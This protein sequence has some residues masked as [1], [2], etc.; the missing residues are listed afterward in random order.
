MELI[1]GYVQQRLESLGRDKD[2]IHPNAIERFVKNCRCLHIERMRSVKD[3]Y[4]NPDIDEIHEAFDD[5]DMSMLNDDGGPEQPKLVNWY[6]AFRALDEFVNSEGR[7]P[8]NTDATVDADVEK[9]KACQTELFKK[10][11]LDRDDFNSAC[12][13]E[14][15]RF[16]GCEPHT[17]AAFLGGVVSQAVLKIVLRQ[18]YPF[19]HTLIYDGIFCKCKTFKF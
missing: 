10:I 13:D 1:K 6:F 16:G 4:W 14:M 11:N 7:L 5:F 9:L 3:E 18:Y 15:V 19:N 2:T 17:I 8:G 12:L